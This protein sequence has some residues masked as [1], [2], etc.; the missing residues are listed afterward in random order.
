MNF[1]PQPPALKSLP[2]VSIEAEVTALQTNFCI[3][4]MRATSPSERAGSLMVV[5]LMM[6]CVK[7]A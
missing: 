4:T 5:V 6:R 1:I 3:E 2:Q 7:S